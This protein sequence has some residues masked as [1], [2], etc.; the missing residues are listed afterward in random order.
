MHYLCIT[1][2]LTGILHATSAL[3]R[4]LHGAGHRVTL[5]TQG[6]GA[7]K[8]AGPHLDTVLL[9]ACEPPRDRMSIVQRWSIR[10]S[11]REA[12]LRGLALEPVMAMV[13]RLDPDVVLI[14]IELHGVIISLVPTG[15]RVGL[16]SPF[17]SIFDRIGVPP[18][19]HRTL[20]S[21][22]LAHRIEWLGYRSWK[23]LRRLKRYV[24]HG[25]LD[26][27]DLYRALARRTG[28]AFDQE[29]D[30]WQW[31]LPFSYRKLPVLTLNAAALDF[32]H[33]PPAQVH[34]AGP[35][36]DTDRVQRA[37]SPE[38]AVRLDAALARRRDDGDCRLVLCTMSTAARGDAAFLRRLCRVFADAPHF[39]AVIGLGGRMDP[40][41]LGDVPAN[42]CVLDWV[43]Q[44][45]VLQ[46]AD[47]VLTNAGPNTIVECALHGVP[48]VVYPLDC[49]DQNGNAARVRFHRLGVEGQADDSPETIRR[50]LDTVWQDAA[51]AQGIQRMRD[52]LQDAAQP[53][54]TLG[55]VEAMF[56]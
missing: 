1:A 4:C 2:N 21:S 6:P 50:H 16:L 14:D 7:D 47:A 46:Y 23:G 15:R 55:A 35:L 27:P 37:L 48:M 17:L 25:G 33:T 40:A 24:T 8:V 26:E 51:I 38:G 30:A 45:R 3:A 39:E 13:E 12:A 11:R 9:P 43:P 49:N 10:S 28:F 29:I 44:L 36:V 31:L 41:L 42:V 20:P 19:H 32:P 53:A 34:H 52:A 56:A 54:R 22:A 5:A 18:L